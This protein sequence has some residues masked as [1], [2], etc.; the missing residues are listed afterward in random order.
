MPCAQTT[1]T[2]TDFRRIDS[3][4]RNILL[5]LEIKQITITEFEFE[6]ELPSGT[7]LGWRKQTGY[8][9]IETLRTIAEHLGIPYINLLGTAGTDDVRRKL[10]DRL[11][12]EDTGEANPPLPNFSRLRS[13]V[14]VVGVSHAPLPI[15]EP[16]TKHHA[17]RKQDASVLSNIYTDSIEWDDTGTIATVDGQHYDLMRE[18]LR[19]QITKN[20]LRYNKF[21]NA[22]GLI[23]AMR[24]DRKL[25]WFYNLQQGKARI[26]RNDMER[27]AEVCKVSVV[28]L[29]TENL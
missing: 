27:I 15:S 3:L 21:K 6:L 22:P 1:S 5:C 25:H 2:L 7:V 16:V 29:L 12:Q 4:A 8:V 20:V 13:E 19:I 10:L 28:V 17:H 11:L 18:E 9:P 24:S 14:S 23:K 26:E